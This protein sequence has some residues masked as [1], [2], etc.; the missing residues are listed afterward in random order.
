[1]TQEGARYPDLLM[2]KKIAQI[3]EVSIDELVSGEELK[4][5][6]EKEQVVAQPVGNIVQTMLYGVSAIVFLLTL[7]NTIPDFINLFGEKQSDLKIYD[8]T[9]IKFMSLLS[10]VILATASI[11][12][13]ITSIRSRLKAKMVGAIMSVPYLLAAIDFLVTLIDMNVNNNGC[14][15][16]SDWITNLIVPILFAACII[17]FFWFKERRIHY[18]F[19]LLICMA[20]LYYIARYGIGTVIELELYSA[21]SIRM[22]HCIGKVS[23]VVLLAFQAYI[24]DKKK[25]IAYKN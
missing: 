5:N 13:L 8:F 3:L 14:M 9:I 1:M 11:V 24:L 17:A 23:M 21:W 18:V 19:I 25:K 20:H 12:G 22:L 10:K 15:Y 2:T 16:F 4:K 7:L 6:I